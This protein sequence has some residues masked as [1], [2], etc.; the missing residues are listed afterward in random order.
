MDV[1]GVKKLRDYLGDE[2]RLNEIVYE[3]TYLNSAPVL[4]RRHL[5]FTE[6]FNLTTDKPIAAEELAEKELAPYYRLKSGNDATLIFESR[7]E[8]G[9]LKLCMKRSPNEYDLYLQN[10]VNTAGN[11]QWFFFR[12][13]NTTKDATVF[14]NIKNLVRNCCHSVVQECLFVQ[15]RDENSSLFP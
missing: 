3:R 2:M 7:F 14:F 1:K 13:S 9:N 12:V 11:V 10:D 5:F 6:L 8:C 4:Q 15:E